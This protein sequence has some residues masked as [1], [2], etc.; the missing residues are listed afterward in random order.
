MAET[1]TLIPGRTAK[2]G[3]ALNVGKHEAAYRE[4]TST[5]EMN[6][7]DMARLG[8]E[9]GDKVRLTTA[10]GSIVVSCR[11]RKPEDLPAA[12]LFLAYGPLS[13]QLMAGDTALSG[14]P[15]SKNL[16]VEVEPLTAGE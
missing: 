4:I 6:Q 15:I 7:D 5:V 9:E 3:V 16:E 11:G 12:L 8:L 14:M 1:M 2:Q 13:S 10:Q